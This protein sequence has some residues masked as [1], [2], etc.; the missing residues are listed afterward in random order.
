MPPEFALAMFWR[1]KKWKF[2]YANEWSEIG[3]TFWQYS[4]EVECE[5]N[6][7]RIVNKLQ[8]QTVDDEFNVVPLDI[9][10]L[11][12][13][14]AGAAPDSEQNL[15]CGMKEFEFSYEVEQDEGP[16]ITLT[17]TTQDP[18]SITT[19]ILSLNAVG[20]IGAPA[21][22]TGTRAEMFWLLSHPPVTTRNNGTEMRPNLIF[23]ADTFRWTMRASN[24]T[25]GSQL[26]LGSYGEFSY[27]FLGQTFTT[28]IYAF[29]TRSDTEGF[30][31]VLD[32]TAS[33]EAIEYWPYD[34]EDGRGPIYDSATGAQLR[35]FPN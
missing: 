4:D 24:W 27:K 21:A 8:D 16:P 11:S 34:P 14:T 31:D 29:N 18:L 33:L 5:I 3:G 28:D 15:V 20:G 13:I 35:L 30:S 2:S 32:V 12:D 26:P 23:F 10:T 9:V 1:V 25:Q 6:Q 19:N 7:L 22:G 17:E